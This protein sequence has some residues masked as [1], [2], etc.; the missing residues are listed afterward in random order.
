M[1]VQK[2]D[3]TLIACTRVCNVYLIRESHLLYSTFNVASFI[4]VI[5]RH[6]LFTLEYAGN[7]QSFIFSQA[8]QDRDK[9]FGKTFGMNFGKFG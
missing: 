2:V 8:A 9:Y 6:A 4:R 7:F 1:E 5:A 3:N